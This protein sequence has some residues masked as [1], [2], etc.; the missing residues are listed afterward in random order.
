MLSLHAMCKAKQKTLAAL[1][2][3]NRI[4][5]IF[6]TTEWFSWKL[7]IYVYCKCHMTALFVVFVYSM[8]PFSYM[9]LKFQDLSHCITKNCYITLNVDR[10][11]SFYFWSQL[12]FIRWEII[13]VSRVFILR[14]VFEERLKLVNQSIA[15]PQSVGT[16]L[17]ETGELKWNSSA[18]HKGFWCCEMLRCN[19]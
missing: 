10:M 1:S 6:E 12:K 7:I 11:K 18:W 3:S 17:W 14:V 15:V 2:L 5:F 4:F 13:L 8:W 9:K 19:G 16:I